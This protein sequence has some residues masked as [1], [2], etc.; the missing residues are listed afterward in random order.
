[1]PI[2]IRDRTPWA[3]Y[4]RHRHIGPDLRILSRWV[5]RGR[6]K[7]RPV[8]TRAMVSCGRLGR[9]GVV[10]TDERDRRP[11][12]GRPLTKVNWTAYSSGGPAH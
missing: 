4:A 6:A 2:G 11:G 1:M 9:A 10:A 5:T 12:D 7:P 8:R 3:S